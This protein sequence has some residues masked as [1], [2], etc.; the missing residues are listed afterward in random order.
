MF[1]LPLL[2]TASWVSANGDASPITPD[3]HFPLIPD[4]PISGSSAKARRM[5]G[6]SAF[7]DNFVLIME[8]VSQIEDQLLRNDV[9]GEPLTYQDNNL[10]MYSSR[11]SDNFNNEIVDRNFAFRV[12]SLRR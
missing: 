7:S 8:N 2:I 4:I 9:I 11:R 3:E 6:D 1:L 10:G 5:K 12:Q